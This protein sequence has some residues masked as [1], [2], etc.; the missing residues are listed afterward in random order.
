M[1]GNELSIIENLDLAGEAN[2]G[3]ATD[4]LNLTSVTTVEAT[5]GDKGGVAGFCALNRRL[6]MP[7]CAAPPRPGRQVAGD[8]VA[9]PRARRG[10]LE[11]VSAAPIWPLT[12]A[13]SLV[14]M[15]L[16]AAE[17]STNSVAPPDTD[18]RGLPSQ[19][20]VGNG[21]IPRPVAEVVDAEDLYLRQQRSKFRARCWQ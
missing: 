16:P 4:D 14:I 8:A 11:P 3:R 18:R 12:V 2:P 9:V 19:G 21:R 1:P 15:L 13:P 20:H 5:V 7:Y 10:I 6:T 17:A